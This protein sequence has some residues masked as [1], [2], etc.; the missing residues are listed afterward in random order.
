MK[1]I[2]RTI[3]FCLCI[4]WFVIWASPQLTAAQDIPRKFKPPILD[5]YAENNAAVIVKYKANGNWSRPSP[6]QPLEL[7]APR[8]AQKINKALG[9]NSTDGRVLDQHIQSLRAKGLSS[10]EL[11][12]RLSKLPDVEWAE[13]DKINRA[14]A[15]PNDPF[16]ANNLPSATPRVGQ[17]YLRTPSAQT[18]SAIDA[19]GAWN[20]TTGNPNVIVAVLD[21]GIRPDHPDLR[22]KLVPG[23][24]FISD[25]FV[26]FDGNG[27]DSNA[28]D[29]GDWTSDNMCAQGLAGEASS[30]HGTEVAGLIGAATNNATGI[31]G[32]GYNVRILPVRVL[33][34]CGGYDSDIIAGMLWAAG[35]GSKVGLSSNPLPPNPYPAKILNLSLGGSGNC[36][37]AYRA[38]I[39][40]L[41]NAQVAVVV[42][43]GNDSNAVNSPGN[44]SGVITVAGLEHSGAKV[45]YSSLGS[46]VSIS[47]PGGN[48][49]NDFGQEC[50]YPIMSTTNWGDTSP[51]ANGYSDSY[52]RPGLGTSFSAPLVAGTIG[53][54]L[55][56]QPGLSLQEIKANLLAT[57]TP[58]PSTSFGTPLPACVQPTSQRLFQL[59]CI[60]THDTCGAGMLNTLAAVSAI[61]SP[62]VSITPSSTTGPRGGYITL[63]TS[64]TRAMGSKSIASYIWSISQGNGLAS[65]SGVRNGSM[66]TLALKQ[67]GTVVVS[68]TVTDSQKYSTTR[69]VTLSITP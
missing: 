28:T 5:R 7:P 39:Q 67:S 13:V 47:A 69:Q 21:T 40:R 34:R 23:F 14:H 68:L 62:Q 30:W 9:L 66:A 22:D 11:A 16:L 57:A 2:S 24:D 59:A 33:G 63:N 32:V 41:A 20:I 27:L 12:S 65:F 44:C 26:S 15:L 45:L 54:M 53:L 48:C 64:S 17:W 1:S 36:S 4:G 31:A 61:S 37:N 56:A 42:S 43:A 38:A 51:G 8:H 10:S 58:F 55:S 50:L 52:F 49:V 3:R 6:D 25:P 18:P 29:P 60:C 19:I 46:Q 35:L